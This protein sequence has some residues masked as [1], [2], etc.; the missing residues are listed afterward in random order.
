M[1]SQ[2]FECRLLSSSA[3]IFS[4]LLQQATPL[5]VRGFVLLALV[6]D[7]IEARPF[8]QQS[9]AGLLTKLLLASQKAIPSGDKE[10]W[11]P[12]IGLVPQPCEAV[13]RG[14]FSPEQDIM[15]PAFPFVDVFPW[16]DTSD[17]R[18]AGVRQLAQYLNLVQPLIVA[19]FSR[20]SRVLEH[21]GVPLWFTF[22]VK[23]DWTPLA[24]RKSD[25]SVSAIIVP[26][27]HRGYERYGPRS[28]GLIHLMELT[29]SIVVMIAEMVLTCIL[30]AEG[31]QRQIIERIWPSIVDGPLLDP[32]LRRL[33]HEIEQLKAN[34]IIN[35]RAQKIC[36][37]N[38][39]KLSG[40]GAN[41][42]EIL[43]GTAASQLS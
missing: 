6:G 40:V 24:M 18:N 2:G 32:R 29:R 23:S 34:N 14:H 17:A 4:M 26:N 11:C 33:Y 35:E 43:L 37:G 31:S 39:A 25:K 12:A 20:E 8:F 9:R 38:H 13:D 10:R 28:Q 15:E 42:G 16:L 5:T 27:L 36:D 22:W 41:C 1:Q 21:V 30:Q 19:A 3:N 7:Y